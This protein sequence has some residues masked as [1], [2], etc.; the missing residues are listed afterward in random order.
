MHDA[1]RLRGAAFTVAFGLLCLGGLG[2]CSDDATG[3]MNDNGRCPLIVDRVEQHGITWELD[4]DHC[5]GT[6]A[7]G[8]YWVVAPVTVIRITPVGE[9]GSVD[10]GTGIC[11]GWSNGVAACQEQC[12]QDAPGYGSRCDCRLADDPDCDVAA[13]RCVCSRIRSGWEVNPTHFGGQGFDNRG[14]S[15][16]AALVPDLP[17]SADSTRSLVKAISYDVGEEECDNCLQT[18]SVLTVVDAIPPDDGGS[19]FRPPYVG[20]A[21]PLYSVNDLRTELLP[22][23]AAVAEAPT[24]DQV[25][26]E[27]DFVQLDHKGGGLGRNFHPTDYMPDYGGDIGSRNADAALALMLDVPIADKLPALLGYVQYGIEL[28]H[29]VLDGHVWEDGGGHRPGQ[30]LPL[31]LAAVLLD[32]DGM[33]QAVTGSVEWHED[34]GANLGSASGRELYGFVGMEDEY[35]YWET[36]AT[37]EGYK[38]RPDPYGY[39]D[40][41]RIPGGTYD[42]CCVTQPWKGEVLAVHLMPAL[43]EIWHN[44]V[45]FNYIDRWVN[46]GTWTQPDPCAPLDGVCVGGA[47]PGAPCTSASVVDECQGG[48]MEAEGGCDYTVHWDAHYG[49]TYGPDGNGGCILDQDPSD[50]IGRFPWRHGLNVDG[51]YRNTFFAGA[52]FRRAMWTSYR[53]PACYDGMCNGD[54]TPTTC[55]YDCTP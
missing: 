19:V 11:D 3:G 13:N 32:H 27:F 44:Q 28:Y 17:Y 54:E 36:L 15:A 45:M 18:V 50:G 29:M 38:S 42:F 5:V 55:P 25:A 46:L 16:D 9:A 12:A 31:A 21:K 7:T 41:G 34:I 47:N 8:D 24:M 43:Q 49:V 37:Q 33:R 26:Q 35:L 48:D 1:R 40:G 4:G 39:I 53:G 30:K 20:D 6:F 10:L 2:G 51:G 22:S 52:E 23:L 14:G